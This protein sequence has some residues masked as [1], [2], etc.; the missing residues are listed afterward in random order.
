MIARAVCLRMT[1]GN[2][3]DKNMS[4]T[5]TTTTSVLRGLPR[6][7]GV[8][9]P[10]HHQSASAGAQQQQPGSRGNRG[11]NRSDVSIQVDVGS[12]KATNS[13]GVGDRMGRTTK[14]QRGASGGGG[15][16]KAETPPTTSQQQQYETAL[17][18]REDIRE[19]YSI[20]KKETDPKIIKS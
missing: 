6:D 11:N 9:P 8:G 4:N 15:G 13:G 5:T 2:N 10:S 14:N 1:T 20:N 17:Y 7:F 3:N 18:S 19:Q 12:T 16:S